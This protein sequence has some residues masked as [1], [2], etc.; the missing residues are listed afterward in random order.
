MLTRFEHHAVTEMMGDVD[1]P[2]RLNGSLCFAH[3]WER[4]AFGIALAL[5][6]N[7]EFEWESFRQNLIEAIDNWEQTHDLQDP[8]W[9]YYDRFLEALETAVI[10][11]GLATRD[12]LSVAL[13]SENT[14]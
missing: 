6:K 4:M 2:P 5:A 13:K 3:D 7:G 8:S 12:E 14:N 9:N 11:A 10:G 1:R